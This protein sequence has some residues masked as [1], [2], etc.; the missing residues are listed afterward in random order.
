MSA[1]ALV[2]SGESVL[3]RNPRPELVA[4]HAW[5]PSL[6]RLGATTWVSTF[7][8]GQGPESHDYVTYVSRSHDDGATWSEPVPLLAA[9]DRP[10]ATHSIRVA[11]LRD[12][13]LLGVGARFIRSDPEQ[14]LINHPG[15]GYTDMEL[16]STVSQDGGQSW[17]PARVIEPP[18]NAPAFETC[19]AVVELTDGRLLLPTSTWLG[20][21]GEGPLGMRALCLISH[22]GGQTW[23]DFAEEFDQWDRAIV[24]WEQSVVQLGDGRLVAVTWSLDTG[25]SQT[26]PTLYAV[27]GSDVVFGAPAP[28]G[29]LAQTMKLAS[30][31]GQRFLAVYRRHDGPGLWASVARLEAEVW[32]TEST[33]CLWRGAASGMVGDTDVGSELSALRFGYPSIVVEDEGRAAAVAFWCQVDAVNEIRLLRIDLGSTS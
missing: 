15:L 8:I 22:D 9:Q 3:Y 28:T 12:G 6:C 14:G 25:T 19:H 16:V 26:L 32:V 10:R 11:Q 2:V 18:V 4:R 33:D 5:H 31:G 17:T 29:L 20:W 23:P 7:D 13:R 24:S 27:A 1:R 30:L 21:N